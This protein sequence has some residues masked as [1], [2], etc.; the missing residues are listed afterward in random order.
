M[1]MLMPTTLRVIEAVLGADAGVDAQARR[2]YRKVLR[3]PA[4]RLVELLNETTAAEHAPLAA[5]ESR[6]IRRA[7]TARRLGCSLRSV[8]KLAREGILSKVG[9]PGRMRKAGFLERDVAALIEGERWEEVGHG[10]KR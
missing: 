10:G 7:E 5:S 8:D 2:V 4:A 6:W 3:M 1:T 9:L